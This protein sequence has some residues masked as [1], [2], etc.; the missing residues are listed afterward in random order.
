MSMTREEA[1][2]EIQN[3]ADYLAHIGYF[4]KGCRMSDALSILAPE[5]RKEPPT[6]E[7]VGDNEEALAY[8]EKWGPQIC[9]GWFIRRCW[10]SKWLRDEIANG[11]DDDVFIAWLPLSALP[12]GV[13]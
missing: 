8:Y 3:G 10:D 9:E 12:K 4:D 6:V 13:E 2:A 11:E 1:I 5:P 7:E